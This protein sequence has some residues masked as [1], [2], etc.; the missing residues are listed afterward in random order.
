MKFIIS[1]LRQIKIWIWL[2]A[3][4]PLSA[5]AGVFFIW[6]FY[7][8]TVLGNVLI[9]GE[10]LMFTVAV[11]WW[12]WAMYS[13]RNLVKHWGKT[14]DKVADVLTEIRDMKDSVEQV[15]AGKDK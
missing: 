2:A 13:M 1:T 5:L 15:F 9:G 14:N 3:I 11:I 12:W 7:D 8:G 6:R 4:L 10:I